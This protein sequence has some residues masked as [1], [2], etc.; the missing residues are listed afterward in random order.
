MPSIGRLFVEIGG[1]TKQLNTALQECVQKAN[2]AG[3]EVTQAGK[4]FLNAFNEALNPAKDLEQQLIL[5][6]DAGKTEA[7]IMAVMG[8][9]I[10]QVAEQTRAAGQPAGVL[11]EAYDNLGKETAKT[12]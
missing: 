5:L 6:Q 1:D 12:G 8:D 9:R 7:E 11:V 4:R 2:A 10:H 3:I